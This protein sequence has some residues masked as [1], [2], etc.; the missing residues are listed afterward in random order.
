[1]QKI[2]KSGVLFSHAYTAGMTCG[3]SRASLDTGLFTQTHGIGGGFRQLADTVWLPGRL[4]GGGYVSSHPDGYSLEAERA[5]HE[6]WLIDLGYSQPLSSLNGVESM[7]H[8]LDLP[9]KWKCGRAG[10]APEHGFDAYCAQRAIRF[11]ETNQ[12][13]PSPASC[14]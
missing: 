6:K 11:L 12:N 10:V 1:M 13:V 2:A 7:A 8:Y 3:P 5:E 9:L 4:A 14:S